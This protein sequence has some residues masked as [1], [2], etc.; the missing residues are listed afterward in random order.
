VR[1]DRKRRQ[2]NKQ[3]NKYQTTVCFHGTHLVPSPSSNPSIPE[4]Y[5]TVYPDL[6]SSAMPHCPIIG[7]MQ[8]ACD[9]H[10]RRNFEEE[11]DNAKSRERSPI[12]PWEDGGRRSERAI[13]HAQEGPSPPQPWWGRRHASAQRTCPPCECLPH[14]RTLRRPEADFPAAAAG[15]DGMVATRG[16]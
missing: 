16:G 8:N 13:L 5:R 7:L 11:Q 15:V 2:N 1:I 12:T 6:Y 3:K 10:P 9:K 4:Q 14:R